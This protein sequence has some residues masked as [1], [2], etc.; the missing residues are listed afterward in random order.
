MVVESSDA[1]QNCNVNPDTLISGSYFSGDGFGYGSVT[2]LVTVANIPPSPLVAKPNGLIPCIHMLSVAVYHSCSLSVSG[3]LGRSSKLRVA[4]S[5]PAGR[6]MRVSY[7]M[8]WLL[9]PSRLF[10]IHLIFLIGFSLIGFFLLSYV[11]K[12]FVLPAVSL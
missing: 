2:V 10:A 11:I 12:A 4:G 7:S 8:R 9:R 1:L 3:I 5:I 6:T